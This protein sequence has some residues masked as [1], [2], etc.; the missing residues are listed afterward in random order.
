MIFTKLKPPNLSENTVSLFG[1]VNKNYYIGENYFADTKN[2][3]ASLFPLLATRQKRISLTGFDTCPSSLHTTNGIT[4]TIGSEL[5]HNGVLQFDGLTESDKK[6]IVSMG[7]NVIVFPDGYYINTQTKDEN[8]VCVEQDFLAQKNVI[9]NKYIYIIPCL[10]DRIPTYSD[11][12]PNDPADKQ[13]WLNT[14][15]VPNS[16]NIY[17]Q[18]TDEWSVIASTHLC[19]MTEGIDNGLNIGDVVD[20]RGIDIVLEGAYKIADCGSGY[21]VVGETIDS[22]IKIYCT[23]QYPLQVERDIPILDFVCEHQNRLFGCRYG[24]NKNGDFVNEI[25]ASKLGDPKNWNCY[26]GLSTDSYAASCG[27]EGEWTG[28]ISHMGYVVFFKENKIHRLFGTKPANYTLYQDDFAGIKKGSESSLA[29]INGALIYHSETGVYSYT[30]TSPTCISSELGTERFSNAVSAICKGVYYICFT[31]SKNT[32]H[33]YTYDITKKI[34]HR[35][36]ST[37]YKFL[38]AYDGNILGV[39]CG[40]FQEL[41]LLKSDELPLLCE[42]IFKNTIKHEGV[43]DWYVESGKMGLLIDDYKYVNKLKIRLECGSGSF[44]SV[45]IML[46]SNGIWDECGSITSSK[47]TPFVFDV[48]PPRCDHFS[49]KI[50]GKGDCKIFSFTK[51]IESAGEV[52]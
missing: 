48:I 32:R 14:S 26:S 52:I 35:E 17:S 41:E 51:V 5:W 7:S 1:G 50:C 8:G 40:E 31:D 18:T 28:I 23:E 29:L 43:F 24:K 20:I 10:E 39:K 3:T 16:L 42:Q 44:V 25:Y 47:L 27:S 38:S 21:I 37:D 12:C 9:K 34:W 22:M 45:Y 36:D 15:S 30:G 13:L 4:Y 11:T 2:T 46:D 49:I 33:L 19:I 6:Q